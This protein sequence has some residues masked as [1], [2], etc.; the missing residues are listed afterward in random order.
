MY[1]AGLVLEGGGMRGVYTAGALDFFIDKDIWFSSVYGVSAGACHACS[2][3]SKQ[4]KR[5]FNVNVDYLK[6]KRYASLYS[7]FKT[8]DYFGSK[9]VYDTIPN[10]L[11]PYDYDSFNKYEGNFCCVVTNCITGRAE[12]L[13]VKDMKK[14]IDFIRAS[15][16]LPMISGMVEIN[17]GKYLD[18]GISDSIP[19]KKSESDGNLKNVVILTRDGKYRKTKNKMLRVL[20][21]KYRK[22]P[23]LVKAMAERHIK[24]NNT[25]DY[26]EKKEKA[27]GIYVIRPQKPVEIGR[28]EKNKEKLYE[29]YN[30]GYNDA[31]RHYKRLI[32]FLKS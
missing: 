30:E 3:L 1:N 19:I 14:D 15:S 27:G 6:D 12:Y 9:F 28:L 17:G 11:S 4:R 18:G 32:D 13:K 23:N 10:E 7:L 5:A 25:L 16:S 31:K 22:Y 29:H 21:I 24:Y 8:G 20:K 26:I 2:Y